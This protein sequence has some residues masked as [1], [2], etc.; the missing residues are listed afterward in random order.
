MK[1]EG[2]IR[3]S[4]KKKNFDEMKKVYRGKAILTK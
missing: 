4:V 2:G 1:D 3:T